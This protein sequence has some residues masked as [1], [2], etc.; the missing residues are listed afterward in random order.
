MRNR[1]TV[2]K[3]ESGR[4]AYVS[5]GNWIYDFIDD[6]QKYPMCQLQQLQNV[7]FVSLFHIKKTKGH[8]EDVVS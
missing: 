8:E 3:K 1:T 6:R 7:F 2:F 4:V 5:K